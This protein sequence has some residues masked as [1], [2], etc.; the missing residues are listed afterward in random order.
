MF[1]QFQVQIKEHF[2]SEYP[3]EGCG[4][5][6]NEF[7][8]IACPNIADDPEQNF[9]ISRTMQNKY[10]GDI[11]AVVHSHP[12]GL[13]CPSSSDMQTQMEMAISWGIART[14]DNHCE[15]LFWFGDQAKKQPL[16]G[17]SFRHGVTDCYA[18]IRDWYYQE[19]DTRLKDFPRNWN[20]WKGAKENLYL[21]NF[22]KAG[23]RKLKNGETPEFGDIA[24][25]KIRSNVINHAAV[26]DYEELILHHLGGANEYEPDRLSV[27]EPVGRWQKYIEFWITLDETK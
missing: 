22:Q 12:D 25:M 24:L 9:Q 26:L 14:T 3:K 11:L 2:I 15:D 21:D 4:L 6:V 16:V 10:H 13:R 5:I 18:L 23:F 17:R 8:F 27:Q 7:G 1:E 20:W 19:K